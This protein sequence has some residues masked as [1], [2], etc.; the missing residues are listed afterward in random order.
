MKGVTT[1]TVN[2]LFIT[3]VYGLI[4]A[5]LDKRHFNFKSIVD[6]FY[7]SFT[8][9]SSVGFG[10]IVPQTDKAKMLV[11]TQQLFTL[12]EIVKTLKIFNV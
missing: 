12:S 8:T 3:F 11:M 7:F 4:Y 10:D 1:T 6:P 2:I 5:N 9:M